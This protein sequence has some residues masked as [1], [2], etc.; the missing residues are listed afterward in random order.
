MGTLYFQYIIYN[1][2]KYII[3]NNILYNILYNIYNIYNI[4]IFTRPPPS[5]GNTKNKICQQLIYKIYYM[6]IKK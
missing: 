6:H 2:Y 4:Y 5:K 1:I 3:N